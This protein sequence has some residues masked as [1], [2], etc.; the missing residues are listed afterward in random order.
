VQVSCKTLF[1]DSVFKLKKER[2]MNYNPISIFLD[3]KT[4]FVSIPLYSMIG[5]S[6]IPFQTS[7]NPSTDL[8]SA[9][10]QLFIIDKHRSSLL[11][12]A[13]NSYK[14]NNKC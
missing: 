5:K 11:I 6:K 9:P 10:I 7:T 14:L 13:I 4:F 8:F 3:Q 2:N 12:L 1:T